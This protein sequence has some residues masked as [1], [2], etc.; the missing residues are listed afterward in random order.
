MRTSGTMSFCCT[1]ND[2]TNSVRGNWKHATTAWQTP[3]VWHYRTRRLKSYPETELLP[4][5]DI[6]L[7]WLSASGNPVTTQTADGASSGRLTMLI[8]TD[9]MAD[10]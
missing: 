9:S 6:M 7:Q 5:V 10:T 8:G 1:A 3:S 2:P 4:G